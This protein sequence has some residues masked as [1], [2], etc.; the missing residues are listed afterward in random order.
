MSTNRRAMLAT[1]SIALLGAA[2]SLLLQR[3]EPAPAAVR[4]QHGTHAQPPVMS[5]RPQAQPDGH[6]LSR[7]DALQLRVARLERALVAET[8][9]HR[10]VGSVAAQAQPPEV[11]EDSESASPTSVT[12]EQARAEREHKLTALDQQL[13]TEAE[14]SRWESALHA[15]LQGTSSRGGI[16]GS[17]LLDLECS[18]SFCRVET[19]H[20]DEQA[21][22]RYRELTRSLSGIQGTSGFLLDDKDGPATLVTYVVREGQ[23]ATHA[24]LR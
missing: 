7:L 20:Q 11:E 3:T 10:D 16:E 24:A 4:D 6:V 15:Q 18:A 23:G 19:Q 14:D 8:K 1:L 17:E 2:S 22:Q 5:A 13:R 21:L 9:V 12:P